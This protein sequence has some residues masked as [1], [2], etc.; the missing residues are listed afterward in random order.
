M[1]YLKTA[2]TVTM[3]ALQVLASLGFVYIGIAKF[4]NGFWIAGFARW[5]YSDSFRMLIGVLEV[6]GGVL[7]AFPPTASYAAA[8]LGC[9]LAGA[10]G[11]LVLHNEPPFPPLL[12]I[13]VIAL[14]GLVRLPRMWRPSRRGV[15]PTLD[16]V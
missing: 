8:L 3:W 9:I 13:A 14:I 7:L 2:G 5:G 10:I 12:W 11:T 1:R 16:T 6:A 4:R 15:P